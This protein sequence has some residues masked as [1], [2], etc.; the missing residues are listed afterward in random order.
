MLVS[1]PPASKESAPRSLLCCIWPV[2]QASLQCRERA[3][4][5][6]SPDSMGTSHQLQG[7]VAQNILSL[8]YTYP[9]PIP[10]L[11]PLNLQIEA[12]CWKG[13]GCSVCKSVRPDPSFYAE[14]RYGELEDATKHFS[15]E[16]L[17]ASEGGD[18]REIYKGTLSNGTQILVKQHYFYSKEVRKSITSSKGTKEKQFRAEAELLGKARQENV[19]M[20]LGF[21]SE[22]GHRLLV[23]E[24]VCY[25]SLHRILS[26]RIELPWER[27]LKIATGV[28]KGLQYL[29]SSNIFGHVRPKNILL[30]HD[31]KPLLVNYGLKR[32]GYEEELMDESTGERGRVKRTFE[33]L[34]PEY[35]ETGQ[36]SSQSDVYSLGVILLELITGRRTLRDTN[37]RS[38]LTWVN[39]LF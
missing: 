35:E 3:N 1:S 20:L 13:S 5:H 9:R 12:G 17:L 22:Q 26:K 19:A 7:L 28:A 11:F 8:L 4:V 6:A 36:D 38:F 29:H 15:P 32:N 33:Y 18:E 24:Y 2:L 30:T 39:Q 25:G 14:F 34:A 10:F 31:Y 16:N 27:R 23:Y 21:C 37:G